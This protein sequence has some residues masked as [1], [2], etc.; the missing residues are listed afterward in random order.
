MLP[1]AEDGF[2]LSIIDGSNMEPYCNGPSER[3]EALCSNPPSD[4]GTPNQAAHAHN[5]SIETAEMPLLDKRIDSAACQPLGHISEQIRIEKPEEKK[6]LDRRL[7]DVPAGQ[8]LTPTPPLRENTILEHSKPNTL[9]LFP[10]ATMQSRRNRDAAVR[11]R[12]MRALQMAERSADDNVKELSESNSA[13]PHAHEL[14][15]TFDDRTQ[16]EALSPHYSGPP[17]HENQLS[18]TMVVAEQAPLTRGRPI[19]KPARLVLP[20]KP[21]SQN[22]AAIRSDDTMATSVDSSPTTT[23]SHQQKPHTPPQAADMPVQS[24]ARNTPTPKPLFTPN[25]YTKHYSSPVLPSVN[26]IPQAVTATAAPAGGVRT[27][28]SSLHTSHSKE[29]R[30]EARLEALER[31]NRLLEAALMAVLKTSGTLN[32][33]PCGIL[34]ERSHTHSQ[35][36]GHLA[37]SS[38]PALTPSSPHA[39]AQQPK[40]QG[41]ELKSVTEEDIDAIRAAILSSSASS[42]HTRGSMDSNG[43]GISALEVYLRTKIGVR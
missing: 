41:T 23:P 19:R 37:A 42:T 13:S 40:V 34:K 7:K 20:G 6:E 16:S 43:S 31:E 24:S 30:L 17:R 38:S 18:K 15:D 35:S 4:E 11:A 9:D 21:L 2:G 12:K 14:N 27:S 39:D 29:E 8:G 33:C 3:N 32:R 25:S 1:P 26:F 28:V 36:V 10:A 22:V 5:P